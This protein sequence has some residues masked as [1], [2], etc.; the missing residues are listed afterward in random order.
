MNR[1]DSMMDDT[2]RCS[3]C[4][5]EETLLGFRKTYSAK[6]ITI[7]ATPKYQIVRIYFGKCANDGSMG[8]TAWNS[9]CPCKHTYKEIIGSFSNLDAALNHY[10]DKLKSGD[11]CC[12]WEL[13]KFNTNTMKY[14]KSIIDKFEKSEWNKT[15]RESRW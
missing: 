3:N 10:R 11:W 12:D 14:D 9:D 15:Y 6:L 13:S 1:N 2:G 8:C 7:Y 4:G 5:H